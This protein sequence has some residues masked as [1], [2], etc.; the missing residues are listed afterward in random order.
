MITV[1]FRYTGP[2]GYVHN[3]RNRGARI[4]Y[5]TVMHH[6]QTF[7]SVLDELQLRAVLPPLR[8]MDTYWWF[9]FHGHFTV[10]R[11]L[12]PMQLD[13]TH[14]HQVTIFCSQVEEAN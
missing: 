14:G 3:T 5:H 12:T 1:I 2:P 9:Y 11:A 10:N 7:G 8:N 4:V 13:Y 6:A